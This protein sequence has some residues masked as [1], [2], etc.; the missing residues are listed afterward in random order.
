MANEVK[1][2]AQVA[3]I[4]NRVMPVRFL[5]FLVV[6]IA[7]WFA[8]RALVPPDDWR[9]GTAMAFDTAA[10][11]FLVSLAPLLG[12]CS[13]PDMR[14][15]AAA[16]DA[17]RLLILF[18]TSL[19]TVVVMAAITSELDGAKGGDWLAIGKLV[20]TLL[21]I[22]AF[23]NSVYALHYAHAFYAK[24]EDRGGDAAGI[25]FP[26]T[27]TPDYWDFAYFA[28]TLGMTFQTSDVAVTAQGI[29]KVVL[30]HC[31]AAFVFNIGVIAFTIN[32][33]GG[34]G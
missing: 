8:W 7:A 5:V 12:K 27:K 6:G 30:L 31:F 28:F 23:A 11:V 33:L 24:G 1:R 22:W 26:G 4:G 32:V 34:A 10:L 21:L 9:D 20:A 14:R 18:L 29:R 25:D 15:H 17:G 19:L 3:G 16:N 2:A 13:A